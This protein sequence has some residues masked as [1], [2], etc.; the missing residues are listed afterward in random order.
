MPLKNLETPATSVEQLLDLFILLSD[1]NR[2]YAALIL[3]KVCYGSDL[4][5]SSWSDTY[6]NHIAFSSEN[7]NISKPKMAVAFNSLRII[8]RFHVLQGEHKNLTLPNTIIGIKILTDKIERGLK[9]I[10]D[11]QKLDFPKKLSHKKWQF[12]KKEIVSI[13]ST[14]GLD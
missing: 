3:E 5:R 13:L 1:H 9:T 4:D 10:C 2:Q 11:L 12:L 7:I 6:L 14:Y 8:S